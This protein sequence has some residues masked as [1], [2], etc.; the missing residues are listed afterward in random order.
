MPI[1]VVCTV[2]EAVGY[3]SDGQLKPI[4]EIGYRIEKE[5]SEKEKP[6]A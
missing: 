5:K 1:F 4:S 3:D 6:D 2:L